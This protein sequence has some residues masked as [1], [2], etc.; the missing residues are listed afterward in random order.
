MNENLDTWFWRVLYLVPVLFLSRCY[1]IS[2][3]FTPSEMFHVAK[4]LAIE[5]KHFIQHKQ[6]R[7]PLWDRY[8]LHKK[9]K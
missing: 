9:E 6:Q 1:T 4:G 2:S 3:H 5:L 8:L 7:V